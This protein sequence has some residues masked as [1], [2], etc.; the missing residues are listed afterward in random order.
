MGRVGSALDNA[1]AESFFST[2]EH[3]RLSRRTYTTRVEARQDV[4]R[5]IDDFYNR[6]RKH[7]TNGMKA[8]IDYETEH[9]NLESET[10]EAA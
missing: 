1:A 7:S 6:R 3:E 5:W 9:R 8:P 2:L 10:A 4:A